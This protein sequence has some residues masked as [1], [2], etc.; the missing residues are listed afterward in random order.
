M[1]IRDK[2]NMIKVDNHIMPTLLAN[3]INEQINNQKE[4]KSNNDLKRFLYS[5]QNAQNKL[6]V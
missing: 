1:D 2:L 5:K 6:L 4:I 3:D